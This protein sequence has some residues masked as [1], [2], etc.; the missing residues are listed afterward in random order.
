[1]IAKQVKG[2]SFRGVLDYLHEKEGSRLIAG[3]MGGKSPRILSA[4]FAVSRQLNPRLEKAVYH[5]S[6]S[7]PKTEHLDDDTWSAIADDYIKGM[8]FADSQ[9]VVYRHSDRDHDHVHIVASRIRITDGTTV[10]DSWDYVRSEKL[11]RELEKK[12]QLTPT[13][14]SNQK[15]QRG[16]TSGEMRL[17]E[18]TGQESVRTKLQQKIDE[19]TIEPITMPELV[20]RLKDLG[21][22]ARISWTRTGKMRGISYQLDGVAFSGTHLGSAYTFP[23]LQKHKQISYNNDLHREELALA[24][25]REPVIK[26]I[27]EKLLEPRRKQA[28]K[29]SSIS[30]E[31]VYN[32]FR[33]YFQ[34]VDEFSEIAH[35][36]KYQVSSKTFGEINLDSSSN[37]QT[38]LLLKD[39]VC[40]YHAELQNNQWQEKKNTLSDKQIEKIKQLP[41]SKEEVAEDYSAKYLANFLQNKLRK[42]NKTKKT[43][44]WKF[45]DENERVSYY[46]FKVAQ[47]SHKKPISILGKDEN[48]LD[49]FTAEIRSDGVIDIGKNQIPLNRISKLIEQQNQE[50]T[51]SNTENLVRKPKLTLKRSR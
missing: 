33:Q 32:N 36:E 15:Y 40:I 27:E 45:D 17:I 16:Q 4:E 25:E 8:D 47:T 12:Y 7:L 31:L 20:N 6:L 10:N 1:M 18:R 22:D 37:N 11:L 49:I 44:K 5:S 19:E 51:E 24:S 28:H 13:I 38:I 43:I 34:S 3:N 30:A 50:Q 26:T 48:D 41:Q 39:D 35:Q 9:Y 46:T 23:G 29:A 21:I 2:K 42:S 14:S